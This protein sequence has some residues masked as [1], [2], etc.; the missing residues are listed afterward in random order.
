MNELLKLIVEKG[1]FAQWLGIVICGVI[2]GL[3]GVQGWL[4]GDE[5]IKVVGYG[6]M[7]AGGVELAKLVK[8]NE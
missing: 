2:A 8:G 6:I 1:R 5:I 7:L 4:V 3:G